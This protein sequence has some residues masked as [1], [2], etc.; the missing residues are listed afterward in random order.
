[1]SDEELS[2]WL[3]KISNQDKKGWS[4]IGCHNC[5]DYRTHHY[6][7]DCGNCEWKDGIE[8]WVKSDFK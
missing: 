4:P 7:N 1:M 3:D 8:G 5:A 2:E 6:P